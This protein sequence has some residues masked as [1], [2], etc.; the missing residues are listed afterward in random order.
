M[1]NTRDTARPVLG[2]CP[3]VFVILRFNRLLP[4]TRLQVLPGFERITNTNLLAQAGISQN[5]DYLTRRSDL[6]DVIQ[7][8]G[9]A[10]FLAL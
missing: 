9:L 7:M 2:I 8:H 10:S 6:E 1:E 4:H 5:P 3:I